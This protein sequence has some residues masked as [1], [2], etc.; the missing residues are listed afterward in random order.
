MTPLT[1]DDRSRLIES[2]NITADKLTG[3]ARAY[4][5]MRFQAEK[6]IATD[7]FLQLTDQ[8]GKMTLSSLDQLARLLELLYLAN[9]KTEPEDD[10]PRGKMF[11]K[12]KDMS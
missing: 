4:D 8:A 11:S 1:Q 6:S 2:I 9:N 7:A 10:S 12:L 5:R 3:V